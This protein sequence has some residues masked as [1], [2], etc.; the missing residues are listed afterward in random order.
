MNSVVNKLAPSVTHLIRMDHTKVLAAFHRYQVD[1]P[2]RTKQALVNTVCIS[3]EIHAQLEEEI[4]YPA[5]RGLDTGTVDKSGPE[6]DE[7]RSLISALRAIEPTAP[8]YD[9]TFMNLMRLVIH[10]VADEETILLPLAE[11]ML[12][13]R[14][15]ELGAQ[16]TSRKIQLSLPRAPELVGNAA[17]AMPASTM[18]VGAGALLAGSFLLRNLLKRE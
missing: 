2:P 1:T 14:L 3:I 6:H 7:M 9:G 12:G 13:D 8:D 10:H 16:M 5:M 15:H 4:F 18:I 11:R 17:R